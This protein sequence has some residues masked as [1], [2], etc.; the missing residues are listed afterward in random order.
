[1]S[2]RKKKHQVSAP[3]KARRDFIWPAV[4]PILR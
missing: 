2:K 3:R 1:M 4:C